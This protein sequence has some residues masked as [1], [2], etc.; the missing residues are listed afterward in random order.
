MMVDKVVGNM[1]QIKLA[2]CPTCRKKSLFLNGCFY[3]CLNI[4]CPDYNMPISQVRLDKFNQQIEADEKAMNGSV[5][6][7][8]VWM[9]NQYWDEKKKRWMNA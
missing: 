6:K 4:K 3:E 2:V 9:G 8:K 1:E 5:S 7:A